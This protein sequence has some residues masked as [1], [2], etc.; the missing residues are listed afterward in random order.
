[1]NVRGGLD[2][3]TTK[4]LRFTIYLYLIELRKKIVFLCIEQKKEDYRLCCGKF[5][6]KEVQ[7][8]F[9]WNSLLYVSVGVC[10]RANI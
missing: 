7:F 9:L 2:F 5:V 6:V 1:M 4:R 8:N 3:S 10:I